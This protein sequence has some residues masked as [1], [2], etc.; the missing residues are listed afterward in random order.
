M[1]IQRLRE[2]VGAL[3]LALVPLGRSGNGGRGQII[4]FPV[5]ARIDIDSPSGRRFVEIGIL[6]RPEGLDLVV[7]G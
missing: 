4:I 1:M 7:G 6:E 2:I 5:I 3:S